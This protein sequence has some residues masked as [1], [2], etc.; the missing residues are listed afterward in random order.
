MNIILDKSNPDFDYTPE[1]FL[2]KYDNNLEFD[3]LDYRYLV[4]EYELYNERECDEPRRWSRWITS[5][6][7]LNGRYFA[8]DWDQGLTEMQEDGFWDSS[9]KEVEPYEETIVVKRW[10]PIEK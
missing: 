7:H 8:V 6:C 9:I 10:R 1:Y 2:Y 4:Y 3:E 5:I